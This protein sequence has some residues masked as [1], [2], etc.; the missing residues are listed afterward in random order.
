LSSKAAITLL[1]T[2][3]FKTTAELI[4]SFEFIQK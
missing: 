1:I 3:D 4:K 2:S